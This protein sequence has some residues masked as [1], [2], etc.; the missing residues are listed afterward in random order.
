MK[1]KV[2][3]KG[4]WTALSIVF[5]VL[6]VAMLIA[7]PI[8]NSY[9]AI[10]N[11][12]LGTE[13]S[14]VI[15]DAGKDYFT[16]DFT[17]A[18][19]V[20]EGQKVVESIVANGS[21]LLLNRENALPLASGSKITLMSVN[22]AK[23][24]YGGTGSGGMKTDGID[25][26]R[27]ALEKDGFSVNPTMWAFYTEGAG[28]DYGRTLASGSLNNYIFNNSE[29][30]INEAPLSA[31]SASEWNS[32]KEYG[33]AAVVVLSRVC[34]EG[35]DLPWYGAGDADGNILALSREEKDMLGKLAELKASGDLKKIVVL[36]NSANAIEMDFIEPE[37]CG[38]DYGID[39]VMWIGEVG[40]GI[41]AVGELLNGS[42]NPSGKL[43]D[44]YCYDNLTSPA[45]QNAHATSYT[46][47]ASQGL[48]FK[49]TNNE[50]YVA[51]QEGIYVGY[52]Y[53]ETRYEDAVLGQG[54]AGDFDYASTVAF[55]FGYGLSYSTFEYAN[56]AMTAGEKDFTFTVDVTNTSAVDGRE[57][58]EIYMQS[59][60]TE[61]DRANGIE[62]AAVELVGFQ[63]QTV[64]AGETVTFTV[65]VD[66]T[67]LRTYD[68]N[69]VGSYILDAGDYYFAAGNGAHE[70]LN[71][72]L[73]AKGA[74]VEGNTAL[75][76]KYTVSAQ[77]NEIFSK[78][79][80]GMDIVNRL[81][82]ADPNRREGVTDSIVY[83]TRSDWEGTMPKATLTKSDYRAA[84][85][86]SASDDMVAEMNALYEKNTSG[87]MPT[88]GKEG[89]LNLAQ[90]IGVPMDGSI[91]F[92]GETYTW[93][94][95]VSQCTF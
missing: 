65:T 27:Q 30:T 9:E 32:V 51:Y 19:Q 37:I 49:A 68:A 71:N 92:G 18:Q 61:Y 59:P 14:K 88:I 73:A 3:G 1:T 84:Y 6:F 22:S 13:S 80:T 58:V 78:S 45:L 36:L 85:Q 25:D 42:A 48:A 17:A 15:G 95:L 41:S 40:Q 10:I 38:A 35:A 16:A 28:K 34:G 5:T 7:G 33:D 20:E 23:F 66:K 60:Y 56:F 57:V 90:F 86:M 62:K 46:N 50:Y 87:T 72:I 21:V 64:K 81:D 43:V 89:K 54:N 74:E 77:D 55:P 91:E 39:A 94:D 63:K 93:D 79:E 4:L 26:L 11:M 52:R 67:E 70:A 69:G 75:T 24:V 76:A 82:H 8:A 44:T 53:Y 83:L 47:A 31:Y 2:K 29:F 12:V